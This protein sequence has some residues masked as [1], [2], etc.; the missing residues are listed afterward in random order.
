MFLAQGLCAGGD[1]QLAPPQ[2]TH[3]AGRGQGQQVTW[4]ICH[5]CCLS[6]GDIKPVECSI[7]LLIRNFKCFFVIIPSALRVERTWGD[8]VSKK[9]YSHFDLIH[10][11]G[12]VDTVRGTV[13]R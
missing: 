3:L 9:K 11:I 5:N 4:L 8:C 2:C 6:I 13:T 1:E 7:V 12:G 10:M